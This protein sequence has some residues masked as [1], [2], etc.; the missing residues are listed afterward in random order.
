[1]LDLVAQLAVEAKS[2]N[3]NQKETR[4]L[5]EEMIQNF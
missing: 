4:Q 3:L 2:L 5:I 1:M